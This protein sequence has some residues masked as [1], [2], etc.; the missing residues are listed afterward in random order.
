MTRE[1]AIKELTEL[2]PEEFLSEYVDAIKMGIEALK[3][4]PC[5]DVISRQAVLEVIRKCHCEEW[6]K[7]DIGAPIEALQSVTPQP[8]MGR[9][10]S[11]NW[12]DNGIARWGIKCDQCYKEY[13]YGGEMGGTYKYCPFCGCAMQEVKD[14]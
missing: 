1:E 12:N 14:E 8:K 2:L 13:R 4:Q 5:E 9:W 11:Y 3:Q 7:A 6:V 10:I